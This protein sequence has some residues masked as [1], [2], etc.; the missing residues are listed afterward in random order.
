M[1]GEEWGREGGRDRDRGIGGGGERDDQP[2]RLSL[3]GKRGRA[4]EEEEEEE[5]EFIRIHRIL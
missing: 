2:G 4:E 1:F 3:F 5:E